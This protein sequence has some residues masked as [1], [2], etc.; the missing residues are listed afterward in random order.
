MLPVENLDGEDVELEFFLVPGSGL[1]FL[2]NS[3][4]HKAVVDEPDDLIEF[5]DAKGLRVV[6]P[7]YFDGVRTRLS[8]VTTRGDLLQQQQATRRSYLMSSTSR[9]SS[10]AES[11]K[12]AF[13]FHASSHLS[14]RDLEEMCRRAGILSPQL[15]H[16]LTLAAQSC[17]SCLRTARPK[18]SKEISLLNVNREFHN[19]MQVDIF[20]L[21]GVDRRP[22]LHAVDTRTR[23]SMARLCRN[24]DLELL[25]STLER[26][27]VHVHG[28]PAE[29][30]GDQ[31]FAQGYF[32]NM[33]RRHN[34]AF[35]EQSARRHNTTGVVERGNGIL[36]DFIKHL[37]L[38]IQCQVAGSATIVF[39]VPDI[40]CQATYFKNMLVGNKM[41]SAFEQCRGYQP[42][43]CG[44][45]RCFVTPER[46]AA[47]DEM[48]ARRALSRACS[49]RNVNV[50]SCSK[51][52][53]G[54]ETL[55]YFKDVVK[56]DV[57][58]WQIGYI[59]VAGDNFATI[60]RNRDGRGRGLKLSRISS[61]FRRLLTCSDYLRLK[62]LTRK[63]L[64]S[65]QVVSRYR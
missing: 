9:P 64:T 17:L 41:L 40:F 7:T 28:P 43:M 1:L 4:L 32:Q 39:T 35:R 19:S 31:E 15:A 33:L 49:K 3:L 52:S 38:D 53:P 51:L 42:S 23:F 6:T 62:I 36:K 61:L 8:V 26:E 57:S 55:F 27:W 45:H 13:K 30:L 11:E 47:H 25:A 34:I 12:L 63:Y 58:R 59:A 46:V 22:I 21:D 14:A 50:L 24:R 65:F 18:P 54:T 48:V 44:L 16:Y 29:I 2:R 56:M 20:Y 37:V 10:N 5:T 60:R